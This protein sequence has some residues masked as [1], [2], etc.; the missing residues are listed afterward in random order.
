LKT[1]AH[2]TFDKIDHAELRKKAMNKIL[3]QR[4][5]NMKGS[6]H[7]TQRK[8]IRSKTGRFSSINS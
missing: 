4:D 6:G 5:F 2:I 3:Q 8:S 7:V 1:H